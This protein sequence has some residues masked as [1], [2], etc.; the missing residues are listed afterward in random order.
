MASLRL[1]C[2]LGIQIIICH[3][4]QSQCTNL[5]END[6]AVITYTTETFK[7]NVLY[8]NHFT[9]NVFYVHWCGHCIKF[10][11]VVRQFSQEIQGWNSVVHVG[12]V[13]CEDDKSICAELEI[14]LLPQVILIPPKS[15]SLSNLKSVPIRSVRDFYD[16]IIPE[17]VHDPVISSRTNLPS[18]LVAHENQ[19][20]LM[21]SNVN[22][23]KNQFVIFEENSSKNSAKVRT[24]SQSEYFNHLI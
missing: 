11:S 10:S 19:L 20:C 8:Q 7:P 2:W 4:D 13:N 14:Q 1:L 17:L 21:L 3:I 6:R 15:E 18:I 5:Y 24:E 23:T 16:L 12:V 9:I 22:Q